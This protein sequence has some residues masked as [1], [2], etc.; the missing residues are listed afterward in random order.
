MVPTSARP[1]SES[2]AAASFGKQRCCLFRK[3]AQLPLSES[4]VAASFGKQHGCLFRKAGPMCQHRTSTRPGAEC[5][6]VRHSEPQHGSCV[7]CP[8]IGD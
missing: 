5:V 8:G 2:S 6:K 1:L 3:A 4:S 7:P